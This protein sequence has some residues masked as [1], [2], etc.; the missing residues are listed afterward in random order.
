MKDALFYRTHA[1]RLEVTA[2]GDVCYCQNQA[3]Q[4]ANN[5]CQILKSCSATFAWQHPFCHDS[6]QFT[7]GAYRYRLA[8]EPYRRVTRASRWKLLPE[9]LNFAQK[10]DVNQTLFSE[11]APTFS[12]PLVARCRQR[13]LK[14]EAGGS[15]LPIQFYQNIRKLRIVETN[16]PN[17]R[18]Q[19]DN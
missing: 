16:R 10:I 12:G 4:I 9:A 11:V 7:G 17:G 18:D 14:F 3:R 2:K 8:T 13:G 15:L 5:L 6:V 1:V 19:A